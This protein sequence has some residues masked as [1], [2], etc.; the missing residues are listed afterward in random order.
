MDYSLLSPDQWLAANAVI[1]FGAIL[2]AATGLGSG[3]VIVPLLAL[4][5]P[6]LVPGPV[7]FAS[8][9]LTGL[10]AWRGRRE[11]RIASMN[12]A[13]LGMAFGAL[14]AASVV[15]VMHTRYAGLVIGGLILLAVAASVLGL[16]LRITPLNELAAG[17]LAG[18]TGTVAAVGAPILALLYQHEHGPRVRAKLAYLYMFGALAA[19][20]VLYFSGL[21]H[22]PQLL[23]GLWLMPAFVVGYLAAGRLAAFLDRG[24]T[25]A[26]ILLI[27][28]GSAMIVMGRSL[29]TVLN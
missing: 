8:I 25:R 12:T 5:D 29:M 24:Y 20:T 2:Q 18:F 7:I 19:M 23:L 27:S 14:A 15:S 22:A 13:V 6:R 1:L 26:A 17:G 21:F 28:G 10:M 16:R 4:I 11:F 3:L 9:A